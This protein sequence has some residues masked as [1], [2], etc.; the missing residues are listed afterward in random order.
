ML[1]LVGVGQAEGLVNALLSTAV[2]LRQPDL[3]LV[4]D[5]LR[6]R[7]TVEEG[8]VKGVDVEIGHAAAPRGRL[9][10]TV[11][12]YVDSGAGQG[13]AAGV[14]HAQ[15]ATELG[16]ADAVG[17]MEQTQYLGGLGAA[18]GAG[19]VAGAQDLLGGVVLHEGHN[20]QLGLV[21]EVGYRPGVF[22]TGGHG[23][24]QV[25]GQHLAF[26]RGQQGAHHVVP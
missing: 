25:G 13:L 21:V 4:G 5:S 10:G 11:Y 17:Q 26:C 14:A 24:G 6:Q 8:H 23:K 15:V 7:K 22:V 20:A 19:G 12:A 9:K 18:G 16:L 3:H 1:G 2:Q